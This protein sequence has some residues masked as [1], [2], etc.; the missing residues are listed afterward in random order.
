MSKLYQEDSKTLMTGA[1]TSF[2]LYMYFDKLYYKM[3]ILESNLYK[4]KNDDFRQFCVVD[5]R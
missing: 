2:H 5:Y 3:E 4:Q 1:I